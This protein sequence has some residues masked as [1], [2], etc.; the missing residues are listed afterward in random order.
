[1]PGPKLRPLQYSR[2]QLSEIREVSGSTA[3][4][5]TITLRII[6]HNIVISIPS[7]IIISTI[8]GIRRSRYLCANN[9]PGCYHHWRGRDRKFHCN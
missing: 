7:M 2:A 5:S 8:I 6:I 3:I 1:M 4:A 9:V